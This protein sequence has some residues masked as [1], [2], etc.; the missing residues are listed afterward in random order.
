MAL[1]WYFCYLAPHIYRQYQNEDFSFLGCNNLEW[2]LTIL[3]EQI[4]VRRVFLKGGPRLRYFRKSK[5]SGL[6]IKLLLILEQAINNN[7]QA[8]SEIENW[9]LNEMI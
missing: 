4:L 5:S 3:A 6:G 8:N 2:E 1:W 7:S 9:D